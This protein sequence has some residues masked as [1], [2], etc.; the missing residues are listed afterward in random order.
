MSLYER[1]SENRKSRITHT[2]SDELS[3]KYDYVMVFPMEGDAGALKQTNVCKHA[4][5][6]MT[7]AGLETFCYTSIQDDELI[8]LVR[9]PIAKLKTFADTIDFKLELDSEALKAALA[10]GGP[11]IKPV[12]I[13]DDLKYSPI[14][15]HDN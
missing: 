1:Q 4:V 11:N 12:F 7:K 14:G 2:T 10:A 8:V 15:C 9:C 6:V 3:S 5:D 13:N